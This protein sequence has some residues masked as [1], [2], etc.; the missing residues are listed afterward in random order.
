MVS[1]IFSGNE[2]GNQ[3]T[4]GE[5]TLEGIPTIAGIVR[6]GEFEDSDVAL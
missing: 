1:R 4:Y 3:Q 6:S 5:E 2:S